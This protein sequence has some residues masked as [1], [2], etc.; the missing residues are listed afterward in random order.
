MNRVLGGLVHYLKY[1]YFLPH[2][3][4]KKISAGFQLFTDIFW[5]QIIFLDNIS[6]LKSNSPNML[7]SR[8]NPTAWVCKSQGQIR[9]GVS[10]FLYITLNMGTFY[11]APILK[12]L[13]QDFSCSRKFFELKINLKI[14]KCA[15]NTSLGQKV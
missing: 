4:T 2:A 8:T 11:Q 10:E 1:G 13:V 12:K 15:E 7:C 3:H 6:K 9:T 14:K 5:T